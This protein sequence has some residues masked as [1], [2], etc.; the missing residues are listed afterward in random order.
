[1]PAWL[2]Y[3]ALQPAMAMDGIAGVKSG[4]DA[5][6]AALRSPSASNGHGWHCWRKVEAAGIEPASRNVS[7]QT[8]TR[9]FG[10][11]KS[12]HGAPGRQG[13]STTSSKQI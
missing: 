2:R 1:M 4:L 8:S 7:A 6:L 3:A 13:A 9:V 12:R 5:R 10:Q 11:F